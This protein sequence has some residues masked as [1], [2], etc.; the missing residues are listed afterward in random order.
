VPQ[1]SIPAFTPPNWSFTSYSN[2]AGKGGGQQATS[3]DQTMASLVDPTAADPS[4]RSESS[5]A[6]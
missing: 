3:A 4:D 2:E 5:D 6:A 1:L